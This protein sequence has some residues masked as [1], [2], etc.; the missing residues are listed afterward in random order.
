MMILEDGFNWQTDS[1]Y[2]VINNHLQNIFNV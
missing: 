1:I 2:L